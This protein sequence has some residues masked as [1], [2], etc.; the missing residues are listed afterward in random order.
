MLKVDQ[1]TVKISG[2]TILR[3]LSLEVPTGAVVGLIGRNGAGKT[4]TVR[5]IMGLVALESGAVE[6]DGQDLTHVAAHV[7][8]GH[9]IGYMPEDRRL[10][11]TLRVEENILVPAWARRVPGAESRLR[12][13]YERMP[14]VKALAGRPAT[15]LSGGQQKLVALARCFM[16]GSKVLLLDEPFEGVAPALAQRLVRAVRELAAAE[17]G[18]SVLIC[19]SEFKWPRL[20]ASKIYLIERGETTEEKGDGL[21]HRVP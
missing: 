21:M 20:L 3:G 4:T 6:L 11:P 14:E 8:A 1:A 17:Q 7:R 18:L 19:E 10:I 2:F 13:I 16:S 9:G 15:Q 12:T 5:C